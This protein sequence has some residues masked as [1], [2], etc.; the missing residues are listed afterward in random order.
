MPKVC[1]KYGRDV[2][3]SKID[4]KNIV[5]EDNKKMSQKL[6]TALNNDWTICG[7]YGHIVHLERLKK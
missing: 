6:K 2:P 7:F 3:I 5:E 1:G 4:L